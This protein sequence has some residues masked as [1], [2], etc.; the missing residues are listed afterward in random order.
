MVPA[1]VLGH[2]RGKRPARLRLRLHDREL[3]IDEQH[4][5][6]TLGRGD[7]NDLI[8]R[9]HLVSRLHA[10]I[11]ISRGK[12]VLVDQST[13]GTF[14]HTATGEEAFVRRDSVQLKGEGLIGLGKVPEFE[15]PYTVRYVCEDG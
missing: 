11:E 6:V 12:F 1:I 4:P 7:D 10:R 5:A 8:V 14:V 3:L 2:L 13:N 15:A 9:G